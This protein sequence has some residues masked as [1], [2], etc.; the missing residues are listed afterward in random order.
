MRMLHRAP[1]PLIPALL[2]V[3]LSALLVRILPA[4]HTP[5]HYVVAGTVAT[6]GSLV[7]VF[8]RFFTPIVSAPSESLPPRSPQIPLPVRLRNPFGRTKSSPR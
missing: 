3:G 2:F 7:A 5:L 1:A 8:L 4:P 6:T